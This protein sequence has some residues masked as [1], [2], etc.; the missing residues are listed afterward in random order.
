MDDTHAYSLELLEHAYLQV[1]MYNM[2]TLS[3]SLPCVNLFSLSNPKSSVRCPIFQA[4][5]KE[6]NFKN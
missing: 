4:D 5:L 3:L 1:Y 6:V 2:N